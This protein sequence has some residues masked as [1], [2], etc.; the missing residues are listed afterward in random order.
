MQIV[1]KTDFKEYPL[2]ARGKVRD[3]YDLGEKLLIVATDRISAFDVV[4]Q[5]PIPDKGKVLTGLS[6]FWFSQTRQILANHLLASDLKVLPPELQIHPEIDGR[7]MLVEK[8]EVFPVECVIRGYLAGS[9]WKDYQKTGGI[10]GIPLPK[11][12]LESSKLPQPVFTPTTK[13]SKRHDRPITRQEMESI[14]GRETARI[15]QEKS[16]QLYQYAAAEAEKKGIIIADTKFE[17]ARF[18]DGIKLV[19]EIF[20]PDSSRFW[21]LSAYEPGKPQI[22]FD[23]QYVRDYLESLIWDKSPPSPKLPPEVIQKTR[24]KYLEAYQRITGNE[25]PI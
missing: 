22:S 23:K 3:I 4:L 15:L 20:T 21:P 24:T 13:E 12:L 16:L 5:D 25:L 18:P 8:G 17:F 7:I 10:C 6:V 14:V 1:T 11:G 19:D 2:Y 9:G